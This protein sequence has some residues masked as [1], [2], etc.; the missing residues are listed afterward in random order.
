MLH[1]LLCIAVIGSFLLARTETVQILDKDGKTIEG[2]PR[3]RFTVSVN[4]ST[5]KIL[6]ADLLSAH[7]GEPASPSEAARIQSGLAAIQAFKAEGVKRD[8]AIAISPQEPHVHR[9]ARCDAILQA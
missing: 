2:S 4:G 8:A 7:N 5:R 1:R 3:C 9:T 6:L